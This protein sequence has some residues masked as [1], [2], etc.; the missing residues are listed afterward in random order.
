[1]S[2]LDREAIF[3]RGASFYK[4]GDVVW[5]QFQ[6]DASSKV[7][8]KANDQHKVEYP[9]EWQAYLSEAFNGADPAKFDHDGDGLPGGSC[10]T[11]YDDDGNVL[12][13][14]SIRPVSDEHNH[15]PPAPRRGR[16]RK[17]V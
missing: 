16:P 1:V 13:E 5:F 14:P 7:V 17:K 15:E 10:K 4:E 6:A 12:Y 11:V 9:L 2:K 8:Q 3:K